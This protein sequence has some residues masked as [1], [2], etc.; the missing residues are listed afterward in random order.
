MSTVEEIRRAIQ[1]L[2]LEE[3]AQITAELCGW[4]DDE[5]DRQMKD[6]AAAGKFDALNR[7]ADAANAA[8][9]TRRLDDDAER[10]IRV[11]R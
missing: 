3:R 5:W 7:E 6:D 10:A 11:Q 9:Q 2:K 4:T 8:G 1:K